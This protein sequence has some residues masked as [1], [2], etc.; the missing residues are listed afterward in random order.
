MGSRKM[1]DRGEQNNKRFT[2]TN[3]EGMDGSRAEAIV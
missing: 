2:S 3:T 1:V